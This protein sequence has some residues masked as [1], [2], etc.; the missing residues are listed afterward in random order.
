MYAHVHTH[1]HTQVNETEEKGFWKEK[2][3]KEDLK[4]LMEVAWWIETGVSS[5]YLEPG[6][7]E[8]RGVKIL[9]YAIKKDRYLNDNMTHKPLSS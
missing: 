8:L 5:R 6:K 9:D 1:T 3:F 4:E 2:G 7:K